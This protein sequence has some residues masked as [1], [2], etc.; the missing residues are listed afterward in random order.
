MEIQYSILRIYA[1]FW[2]QGDDEPVVSPHGQRKRESQR[3]LVKMD[4]TK[5]LETGWNK[6][7]GD[8]MVTSGC[9]PKGLIKFLKVAGNVN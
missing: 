5:I 9:F 6:R 7:S 8:K 3:R 4:L 1:R 2:N